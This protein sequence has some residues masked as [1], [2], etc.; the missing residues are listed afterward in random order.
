MLK[1]GVLYGGRSGEHDVSLSSAANIISKLDDK[2]YDVTAIGIDRDGRWYVQDKIEIV[3]DANFGHILKLNKSGNWHINHFERDNKLYLHDSATRSSIVLDLVIPAVHGSYCEDGTLQGL[4]E[5][6][7]VPYVGADHAGSAIGMDKSVT[8]K[9]LRDA[10]I[11][12]VD[13]I[14][15]Y[16]FQWQESRETICETINEKFEYPI[17]VKPANAGSS[18]GVKRVTQKENLAEA[19]DFSMQFDLKVLVEVAVT[20][21]EVECAVLGN[22]K[23]QASVL[24]E[25]IP[26]HDFYSYEA[27]YIDE[28]G[29]D[30]RIPAEIPVKISDMIRQSAIEAFV[31]LNCSGLARIDFF[32]ESKTEKYFFNEINTLPGF[33]NISMYPKLWEYTGLSQEKLMDKLIDY[34]LELHREKINIRRE[35]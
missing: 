30:L 34:A 23:P 26:K 32:Y 5:L 4:L 9:I 16:K 33:T 21:R 14:D 17:F 8:K 28:D 11:P 25:I 18:V 10:N 22:F 1:I 20:G 31:M 12:V 19:I 2:K 13:W 7:R 15:V 3:E 35:I 27:K 6:I 24:G 29:A